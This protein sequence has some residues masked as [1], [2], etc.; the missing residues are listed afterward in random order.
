MSAPTY[1]RIFVDRV[2]RADE[3]RAARRVDA[4][5][6]RGDGRRATD[7]QVHFA[8][9]GRLHHLHD[10]A[11]R[12]AAHQRVVHEHDALTLEDAA[13]GIQLDLDAEVPDGL[14]RLD[15]GASH[16]MIADEAHPQRDLR[17]L[18][19][20]GRG[21]DTRVGNRHDHVGVGGRLPREDPAELRP[22]VVDAAAEHVTVGPREIHVLE[23]ALRQHRGGRERSDR[24]KTAGAD[25]DHLAGFD[26]ADVG[27]P[28]EIERAGLRADDPRVAELPER[29]RPEA[30]RVARR[31]Q[32]I[33][34]QQRERE[35]ASNLRDRLDQRL[36]DRRGLRPGVEME[37][38][39][40]VAARLEDRSAAHE[41]VPELTRVDEVAVVRHRNLPVRAIDEEGLR[42][43][44]A[45]L[46]GCRVARVPDGQMAGEALKRGLVERVRDVP[47]RA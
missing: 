24:S 30:V 31:D 5:E 18:G 6:A 13:H 25:D 1:R 46:A 8:R 17:L 10:L 11:A 2:G 43:V 19:K 42:V 38:D 29:Q 3:L 35:G 40:G 41:L 45:A 14:L 12:R 27:R 4:V 9:A 22:H 33:L 37:E 20:A 28:D 15:E 7:P 26:V 23:D 21:A 44:Q 39:L 16:V 47:H 32:A 36:F 34:R